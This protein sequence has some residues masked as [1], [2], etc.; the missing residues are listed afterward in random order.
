MK[1]K[2]DY[3]YMVITNYK[4]YAYSHRVV[5]SMQFSKFYLTYELLILSYERRLYH[6]LLGVPHFHPLECTLITR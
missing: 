5:T 1:A 6:H 3:L 2:K 4:F